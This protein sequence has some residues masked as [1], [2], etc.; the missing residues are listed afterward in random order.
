M[1]IPYG[2]QFI[3]KNDVSNVVNALKKDLIT[4][5]PLIEKFEKKVCKVVKSKYAVALSSCSA[6]LHLALATIK[7]NNK[8]REI[9]TSPISFV[10]TTNA[11]IHNKFKPVF[12]DIKKDT[13]NLDVNDLNNYLK[14]NKNVKAI[15]PVHLVLPRTQGTLFIG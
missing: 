2:K 9:I 3:D 8:K 1:K 14:K 4:Q 11:I 7:N 5:G 15:L 6:G 10:S 12:L 13:L